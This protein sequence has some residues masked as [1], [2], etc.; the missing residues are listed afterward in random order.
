MAERERGDREAEREKG[1]R[2]TVTGSGGALERPHNAGNQAM[3]SP[4]VRPG[5]TTLAK[6][7]RGKELMAWPTVRYRCDCRQVPSVH[8]LT[9]ALRG[10]AADGTASAL[11]LP[12]PSSSPHG[13]GSVTLLSLSL[14]TCRLAHE[15]T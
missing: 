11:S 15:N 13:I 12:G 9:W 2:E 6:G 4:Q 1:K 8:L 5:S 3:N 7:D 14:P 10:L